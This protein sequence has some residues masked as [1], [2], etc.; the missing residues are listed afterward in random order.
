MDTVE[1]YREIV[2]NLLVHKTPGDE[3]K[4]RKFRQSDRERRIYLSRIGMYGL[5]DMHEYSTIPEFFDHLE[6]QTHN[7]AE[8]TYKYLQ[9]LL[10][11][12]GE[13]NTAYWFIRLLDSNKIIGTLGLIGID[14]EARSGEVGKGLSPK[15]WG[16]G[17]MSEAF[18]MYMD[19]CFNVLALERLWSVTSHGNEANIRLMKKF[20]FN[21]ER[22][23]DKFYHKHDGSDYD[24]V[25]LGQS[26]EYYLG[27]E[28]A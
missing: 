17:Y 21:V 2:K 24:A 20:G 1:E 18:T 9:K 3:E 23:L 7:S 10:N 22:R 28:G 11:R 27:M 12:E 14:F 16:Q 6:F 4:Y 15:Y 19:Y 26:R 13:G 8:E 5:N 25:L